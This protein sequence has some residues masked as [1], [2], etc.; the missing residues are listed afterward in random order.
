[1][2]SRLPENIKRGSPPPSNE[3]IASF[4]LDEPRLTDRT[5][6]SFCC[7]NSFVAFRSAKGDYAGN[8]FFYTTLVLFR[9][10]VGCVE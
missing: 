8:L 7:G 5:R 4:K 6:I 3:Y 10:S 1:M 9:P 2:R